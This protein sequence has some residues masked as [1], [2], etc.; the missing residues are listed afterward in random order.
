[1]LEIYAYNKR[2][3]LVHMSL[4]KNIE[5]KEGDAYPKNIVIKKKKE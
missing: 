1:M 4:S 5:G 2:N 3:I